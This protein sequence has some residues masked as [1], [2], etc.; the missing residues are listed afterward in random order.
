V[1]QGTQVRVT[2]VQLDHAAKL[3]RYLIASGHGGAPSMKDKRLS[4]RAGGRA[5]AAVTAAVTCSA[6]TMAPSAV[7]WRG[8]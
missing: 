5:I 6:V 7:L 4:L 8:A 2:A 3:R 1:R